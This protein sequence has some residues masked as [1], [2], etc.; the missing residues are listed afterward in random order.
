VPLC[1]GE[2]DVRIAG[3]AQRRL[4]RCGIGRRVGGGRRRRRRLVVVLLRGGGDG[5]ERRQQEEPHCSGTAC[6]WYC[7]SGHDSSRPVSS[8]EKSARLASMA[9]CESSH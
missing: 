2:A 1:A 5:E 3:E 7:K 8:K 4:R 6:P 9:A